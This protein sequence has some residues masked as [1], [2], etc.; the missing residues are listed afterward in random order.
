MNG[1][2]FSTYHF[3][4]QY[5]RIAGE[6]RP[7]EVDTTLAEQQ[8]LS[9]SDSAEWRWNIYNPNGYVSAVR[10]PKNY[11]DETFTSASFREDISQLLNQAIAQANEYLSKAERYALRKV[12]Y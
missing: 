2:K 12:L 7:G 1:Q 9:R 4:D 5:E 3:Y 11:A 6:V 8:R 10:S